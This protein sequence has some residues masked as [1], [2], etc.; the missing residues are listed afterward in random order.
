VAIYLGVASGATTSMFRLDPGESI[1][2]RTTAR[3]DGITSAA[4]SAVGDA[5]VHTFTVAF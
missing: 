3:V 2:I 1:T 5:K 4:Y